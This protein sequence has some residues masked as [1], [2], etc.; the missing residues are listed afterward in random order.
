MGKTSSTII[1]A[2]IG[3]VAGFVVVYLFG[4]A[5]KT[6]FDKNYQSRLDK[7]LE[8]GKR[9]AEE[10]EIALRRELSQA[11]GQLGMG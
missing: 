5:P 2:A 11:K 10:H 6:T 7:A 4:P 8:E 3:A 9:A 1:G